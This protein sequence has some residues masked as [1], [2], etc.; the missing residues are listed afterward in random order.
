[1]S[2]VT[3]MDTESE[4]RI[5]TAWD[6]AYF[7]DS[8]F[9]E[10]DKINPL[11]RSRAEKDFRKF[12]CRHFPGRGWFFLGHHMSNRMIRESE[13]NVPPPTKRNSTDI[14]GCGES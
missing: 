2:C 4:S 13:K 7:V 5:S 3:A 1:M 12:C 9:E 6:W 8:K 14:L 10:M 11:A